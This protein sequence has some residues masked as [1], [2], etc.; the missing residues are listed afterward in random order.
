MQKLLYGPHRVLR[1]IDELETVTG[2][3][4]VAPSHRSPVL[5]HDDGVGLD[6]A[7]FLTENDGE[8]HPRLREEIHRRRDVG[9]GK[10]QVQEPALSRDEKR[11]DAYRDAIFKV[12]ASRGSAGHEISVIVAKIGKKGKRRQKLARKKKPGPP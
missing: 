3:K 9:A 12:D 11:T 2:G 6:P 8:P 4:S 1:Q 5:P 10:R 7:F